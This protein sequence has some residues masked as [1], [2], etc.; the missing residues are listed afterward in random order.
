MYIFTH[1]NWL[2]YALM[3]SSNFHFNKSV[4]LYFGGEA[5]NIPLPT[6]RF[7]YWN[8]QR[9]KKKQ[10]ERV[11]MY[12]FISNIWP[13]YS[14]SQTALYHL[15]LLVYLLLCHFMGLLCHPLNHTN[16]YSAVVL[17]QAATWILHKREMVVEAQSRHVLWQPLESDSS[18]IH[19]RINF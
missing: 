12:C 13:L 11:Y 16:Y 6:S 5:I 1:A 9:T 3:M 10:H 15:K 19:A 4:S 7:L 8:L 18:Y 14:D 17:L 2:H